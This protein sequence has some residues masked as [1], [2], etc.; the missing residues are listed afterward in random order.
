MLHDG[1]GGVFVDL[2]SFEDNMD[3][4]DVVWSREKPGKVGISP[5]YTSG[6]VRRHEWYLRALKFGDPVYVMA[7]IKSMPHDDI[8][9]GVIA[10]NASRIH[11]TMY[12]VGEDAVRRTA[13]LRKGSEF[14]I[15]KPK[16]SFVSRMGALIMLVLAGMVMI[17]MS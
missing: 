15:L 3:I 7:R 10:E 4:G 13:K 17:A 2:E 8:P 14:S 12:A 16:T 11:H 9:R 5:L 1:T 6:D